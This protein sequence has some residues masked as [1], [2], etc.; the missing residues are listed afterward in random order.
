MEL[1]N[2]AK[3]IKYTAPTNK[4]IINN[5]TNNIETKCNVGEGP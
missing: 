1:I 2:Y 5:K 3:N 4:N